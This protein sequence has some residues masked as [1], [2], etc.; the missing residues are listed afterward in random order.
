MADETA[1][2]TTPAEAPATDVEAPPE[3]GDAG[4]Q[5]LDRMKAEREEAR[6]A[7]KALEKELSELRSQ[8]KEWEKQRRATMSEAERA[9]AE[10]EERGR[11]TAVANFGSRLARTEYVAAAAKRN[12]DFDVAAVLDD[13]NLA[14][15][16]R[17]DG[18][19]DTA[20]IAESVAR[21]IPERASNPRPTGDVG[22]GP[23][24]VAPAPT[25]GSPRSLIAAGI[26]ASDGAK[27]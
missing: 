19:P 8:S 1:Q 6:K 21:L 25:D 10:A 20:A 7:A 26:A 15:F 2:E 4:K 5:A 23:R 14:K 17:E 9:T 16:I 13:I 24:P 22:L 11:A 18:E 27:H 12:S 3:L